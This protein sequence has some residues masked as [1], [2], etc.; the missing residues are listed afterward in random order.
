MP[1]AT[2][3]FPVRGIDR[4]EAFFMQEAYSCHDGVNVR[5]F[6]TVARARGGSRPG[7]ARYV[8]AR[9]GN[10]AWVL[11][12]L[13]QITFTGTPVVQ[14]SSSG[15]IVYLTAVQQG[16]VYYAE[17]GATGWTEAAN[18]SSGTPP[19]ATSGVVRS[20]PNKLKL[21]YCDGTSYRYFDPAT[22]AVEDWTVTAGSLPQDGSGNKARLIATWRGRTV[23]AG[24]LEDPQNWFMSKKDDPQDWEY[25]PAERATTDPVAGNLSPAGLIGDVVTS[26]CPYND[27]VLIV[28][29]DHTI[30]ALRGDPAAGGEVDL[31]TNAIGG[32][33]GDCWCMDPNGVIYFFSN[34]CG[35]Y[36]LVP[37]Q[38]PERISRPIDNLLEDVN[39]GATTVR[40]VWNDRYQGFHVF[41][42]PTANAAAGAD[43]FHLFYEAR[44]GGW[45]RDTFA[46]YRHNPLVAH[47]YDGN[48]PQDRTV[49]I[50][51]WDGYVRSVSGSAADD[52]GTAIASS[53]TLGPILSAEMDDMLVKEIQAA[54]GESSGEV[55]YEVY[56]GPTA[57]AAL[58]AAPVLTGTWAA[59]RNPTHPVRRAGHAVYVKLTS[60]AVWAM[61]AVRLVVDGKG[62]V[63]R[64]QYKGD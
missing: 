9:L 16:K 12:D 17:A 52:D 20:A 56:V 1:E 42:T 44:T 39:T 51:S 49:L 38:L 48:L 29:G 50:G 27:D 58:A 60:T 54:L 53:V 6:D 40:L 62:R 23:L 33:W 61:E 7:L 15:R 18:N 5:A 64:R 59:G 11:S 30:Y 36:A 35:I 14:T 2:L 19:L 31:I 25:A 4:S 37:G 32:V 13:N 28:F 45:W 10:L 41:L 46:D 57:E 21:W 3:K 63:R 34:L 55:T 22:L 24:V 8:D 47:T 26:L 43:A